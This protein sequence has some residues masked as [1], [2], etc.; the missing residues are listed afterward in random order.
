MMRVKGTVLDSQGAPAS[1]RTLITLSGHDTSHGTGTGPQGR[2]SFQP[3]PP[4]AYRLIARMRDD[5]GE[6]TLEYA[7]ILVTLVDADVEDAIVSM[8]PTSSLT[9]RVVFEGGVPPVLAADALTIATEA[10]DRSIDTQ[11]FLRPSAVAPDLTFTLH[12]LAGELLL[13]LNGRA[14][15]NWALKAVLLG[16]QD[17]TDLP[18]EF[19][20]EDSNRLQVVLTTRASHLSGGVTNDKGEP[21][22]CTVVLFGEDKASWFKSS[23]RFRMLWTDRDG[24]FN[25]KGLRPG[26]YYL[27]AVPP[28]RSFNSQTTLDA[29]AFEALAKDATALVLGEDEQRVV[30]LKIATNSGGGI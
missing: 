5:S 12:R 29:A 6:I 16:N 27:V 13:R 18:T 30:D 21:V 1:A 23:V 14:M 26:R 28:E 2:F 4:G 19:R 9:G 17:I 8:K 25:I 15:D 22:R 11:L 24:R 3:Q 20:A 7:S 10:K